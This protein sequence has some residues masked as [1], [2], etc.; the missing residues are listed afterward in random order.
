[1][2]VLPQHH[3]KLPAGNWE[4]L[5]SD[6]LSQTHTYFDFD[7]KTEETKTYTVQDGVEDILDANKAFVSLDDK[8]YK[9][10]PD[11]WIAATIPTSIIHKWLVED[12]IDVFNEDHWHKVKQRLNSSDYTY[13]R[14]GHF[15][16]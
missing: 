15:Q 4:L 16:L 13:L 3:G 12:G 2:A 7:E 5:S 8:G 9:K 1:M 11:M 14:R 10:D 6:P